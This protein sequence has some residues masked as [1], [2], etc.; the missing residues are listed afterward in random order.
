MPR[1]Y[2]LGD[3][4]ETFIEDRVKSGR[5]NNASEV[6][7]SA[8]RLLADQEEKRELLLEKLRRAIDEGRNSGPSIPADD[9]FDR[10]E[11]KYQAQ[12]D[13]TPS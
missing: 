3:H 4:F 6:V 1:S 13:R 5:Y 2:A 11:A 9:V 10:L 8:L 7:R 12:A